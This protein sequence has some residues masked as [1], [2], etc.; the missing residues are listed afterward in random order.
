MKE[1]LTR[2]IL[3][4]EVLAKG[5]APKLDGMV[6]NFFLTMQGVNNKKNIHGFKV[7]P[8]DHFFLS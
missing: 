2:P 3:T 7:D 5:K 8:K 1:V 6:N 4:L